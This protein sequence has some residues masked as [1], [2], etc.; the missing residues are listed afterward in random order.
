M[1]AE[2]KACII[3]RSKWAM[4]RLDAAERALTELVIEH[5]KNEYARVALFRAAREWAD[6]ARADERASWEAADLT[7]RLDRSQRT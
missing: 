3:D 6:A 4:T 1:G 5:V 7:A 2:T